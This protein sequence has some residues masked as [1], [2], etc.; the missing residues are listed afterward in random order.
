MVMYGCLFH[1]TVAV[2]SGAR[3]VF[4]SDQCMRCSLGFVLPSALWLMKQN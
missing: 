1:E 3:A 2:E 4:L